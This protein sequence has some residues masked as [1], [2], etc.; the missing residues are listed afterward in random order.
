MCATTCAMAY[1]IHKC[2]SEMAVQCP[3]N[4]MKIPYARG[5]EVYG[6]LSKNLLRFLLEI[7]FAGVVD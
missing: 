7:F 5:Q 1:A 3:L 6:L 4:A 2:K